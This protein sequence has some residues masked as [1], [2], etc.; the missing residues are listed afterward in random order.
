[1]LRHDLPF[2]SCFPRKRLCIFN[3]ALPGVFFAPLED[4]KRG[5]Q[6]I[7]HHSASKAQRSNWHARASDA[8]SM[9]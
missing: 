8:H 5:Q 4:K 1:M 2:K 6:A 7:F 9:F 3:P